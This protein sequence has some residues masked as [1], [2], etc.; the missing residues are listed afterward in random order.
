MFSSKTLNQNMPK[1]AFLLDSR[2]V[3]RIVKKF[4]EFAQFGQPH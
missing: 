1:N 4:S 2:H 3:T